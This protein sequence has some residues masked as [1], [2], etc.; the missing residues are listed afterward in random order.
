MR[1]EFLLSYVV[2]I[3]YIFSNRLSNVLYRYNYKLCVI[4]LVNI[5]QQLPLCTLKLKLHKT[6]YRTFIFKGFGF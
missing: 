6:Q 1:R 4:I 2:S 5:K 3:I